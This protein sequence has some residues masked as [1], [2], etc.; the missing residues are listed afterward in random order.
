MLSTSL[1][2]RS[3]VLG[4]ALAVSASYAF[5]SAYPSYPMPPLPAG[6]KATA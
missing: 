4:T 2:I 1:K 5:A 3:V 6:S